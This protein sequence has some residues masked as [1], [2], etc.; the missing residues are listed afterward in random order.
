MKPIL[1][2]LAI[3]IVISLIFLL[4]FIL[5]QDFFETMFSF[6]ACH[7][8]FM[9]IKPYAWL[10]GIALLMADIF[11][12]VPATGVLAS[13]GSVYGI[14][15]GALFGIAGCVSAGMTG[16]G[17]ARLLGPRATHFIA[18]PEERKKFKTFFDHWG[19]YAI[20]IS[21][22][23]P[24]L[25]EVL[26]ILAGMSGMKFSK[27]TLALLTGTIPVCFL[28]AW[29]GQSS[30]NSPVSGLLISVLIPVML[31]PIFIKHLKL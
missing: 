26:T 21:R 16:Y 10:M 20:I 15:P 31:W 12:P 24:L 1:K 7:Q 17:I 3:F 4:S 9:T 22:I 28:F 11:M 8:W 29:I 14:L 27:F 25:P 5:F 6:Q 13:L 18:T 30:G 19:G 2:L 23:L